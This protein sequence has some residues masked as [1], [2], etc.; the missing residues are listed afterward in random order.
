MKLDEEWRRRRHLGR[1]T[2]E[3]DGKEGKGEG[4][5]KPAEIRDDKIGAAKSH[6]QSRGRELLEDFT[7]PRE[8]LCNVSNETTHY[9]L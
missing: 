5:G 6:M 2:E 1:R 4:G 9:I 3:W 7:G 8:T